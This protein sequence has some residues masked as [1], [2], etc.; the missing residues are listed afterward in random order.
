MSDVDNDDLAI[1]LKVSTEEVKRVIFEN[2]S[3]R[4]GDVIRDEIELMGPVRLSDVE[5][6]SAENC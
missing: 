3:K 5:K 2:L 6:I 4:I 1:S